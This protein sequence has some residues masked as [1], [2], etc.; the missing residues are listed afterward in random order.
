MH[1][2]VAFPQT[3]PAGRLVQIEVQHLVLGTVFPESHCSPFSMT[4]LPQTAG[5]IETPEDGT[6]GGRIG[7]AVAVF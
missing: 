5:A 4:P 2:L 1:L 6:G 3:A 7:V